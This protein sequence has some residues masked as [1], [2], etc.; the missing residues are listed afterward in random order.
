MPNQKACFQKKERVWKEWQDRS[1]VE[2]VA[3]NS[4]SEKAEGWRQES[5]KNWLGLWRRG[6][7]RRSCWQK[8]ACWKREEDAGKCSCPEN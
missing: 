6:R 1:Q 2:V 7:W 4:E 5:L 8:V 3:D